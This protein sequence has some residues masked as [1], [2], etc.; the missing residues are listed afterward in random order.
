MISG[1]KKI[2]LHDLRHSHASLLINAGFPP[3]DVS[4]R[5]GHADASI[6]LKIYSHFYDK[7]RDTIAEKLNTM[8][9]YPY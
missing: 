8:V 3:I 5:L 1:V 4:D 6:T 7:K 2:R 9:T